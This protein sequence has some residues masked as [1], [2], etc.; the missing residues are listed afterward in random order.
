MPTLEK[1]LELAAIH[2]AGQIDKAGEPYILHVLRVMHAV[3][4]I[5]AKTV[6]AMHDLLEDT[7]VT[8]QDLRDAGFDPTPLKSI[9]AVVAALCALTAKCV[10]LG[11]SKVY[12]D[13]E[14]GYIF[15]PEPL[16]MS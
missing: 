12:G 11:H 10:L 4:G 2:H 9:D 14:G 6:A 15:V 13:A 7:K 16:R 1:A 5:K 3:E 8:E